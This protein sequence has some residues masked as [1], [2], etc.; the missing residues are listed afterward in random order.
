MLSTIWHKNSKVI[1]YGKALK[2]VSVQN[3]SVDVLW[4]TST[5]KRKGRLGKNNELS[6]EYQSFTIRSS[7]GITAKSTKRDQSLKK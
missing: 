7:I 2:A 4:M 6:F 5:R 1:R 3:D